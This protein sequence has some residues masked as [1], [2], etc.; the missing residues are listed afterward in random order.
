M[1]FLNI[2][3]FMLDP[4]HGSIRPRKIDRLSGILK[5]ASCRNDY[6]NPDVYRVTVIY[7]VCNGRK[8]VPI[9]AHSKGAGPATDR[10]ALKN[11]QELS[12]A[13]AT[14]RDNK[15]NGALDLLRCEGN[16]Q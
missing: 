3:A 9:V 8:K 7:V 10:R 11:H 1:R 15:S 13:H 16:A 2:N 14:G 12:S 6:Y 4:A 5:S